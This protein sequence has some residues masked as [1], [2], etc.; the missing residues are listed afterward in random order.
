[1]TANRTL[2]GK[3]THSSNSDLESFD[4]TSPADD[5]VIATFSVDDEDTVKRVVSQSRE[6]QLVWAEYSARRRRQV[7]RAWRREIWSHR[8]EFVALIHR[9]NGKPTDD[10]LLEI[11][12]TLEHIAWAEKNAAR[13]MRTRRESPG[14]LLANYSAHVDQ[15]PL[16][17]IGVIGPWN[18]PL[19]AANSAVSAALAA[20]NTVVFKPSEHTTAVGARYVRSFRDANPDIPADVLT[21][22]TGLGPTG[23]A[24]C[25]AGVDKIAFTGSTS[26]GSAIMAQ[27]APTLTPVVME[28]GGK[29]PVLVA[30]D[31]DIDVAAEAVA[32]GAFTNG[33]QTCVGV[34]RVYVESAV[35]SRF[36]DELVAHARTVRPGID[37]DASYGPMTM[38]AQLD[39]VRRH[40][41]D[42][43]AAG[44]RALI[45]GLGAVGAR[46]AGP[47]VLV[48]TPEDCTAV[49]EETFG[50][51]V[52]VKIVA[53]INEAV[54]LANDHQY[55]LGASV[56]SRHRGNEIATRLECG[57]VTINSVIAFAGMGSIPMGGAR[58]SGFGRVHGKEGFAEF[59]RSRGRVERTFGVPGFELVSLRRKRWVIPLVDLLLGLRHR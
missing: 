46:F 15:V 27:C 20:G 40:L 43:T 51:T 24:L 4:S 55:A 38:P 53:D 54:R 26:T 45:G 34:E 28:C 33:G 16:G 30:N 48:D 59:C 47:T 35:A 56:F 1:M 58:A 39:V 18:Y 50:P 21:M 42:A 5:S 22:V 3:Q 11:V 13:L 29:D 19:Y 52:T 23:A 2:A 12:L 8:A 6:A 17:V 14:L 9:E 41:H 10:A 44:G 25:Q 36:I 31:A 57:Q 7:L 32:W 37:S 49:R